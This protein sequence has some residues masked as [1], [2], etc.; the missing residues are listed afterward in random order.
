MRPHL[1]TNKKLLAFAPKLTKKGKKLNFALL[2]TQKENKP[3]FCAP[4]TKNKTT[5]CCAPTCNEGKQLNIVP[6]PLEK[7]K[8]R[9]CDPPAKKKK[10][11]AFA[12]PPTKKENN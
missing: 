11:L 12:P 7:E 5:K 9:F 6:L 1:Q 10:T 2:P 4:S 8:H 3:I